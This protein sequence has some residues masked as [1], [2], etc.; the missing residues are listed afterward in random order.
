MRFEFLLPESMGVVTSSEVTHIWLSTKL[1]DLVQPINYTVLSQ[2][3]AETKD[4][5]PENYTAVLD[6]WQAILALH[7]VSIKEKIHAQ[8]RTNSHG[9]GGGYLGEA[10]L[11]SYQKEQQ[12]NENEQAKLRSA[13]TP[14]EPAS[15]TPSP[16]TMQTVALATRIADLEGTVAQL[17]TQFTT[18]QQTLV[19]CMWSGW[20]ASGTAYAPEGSPTPDL[21]PRSDLPNAHLPSPDPSLSREYSTFTP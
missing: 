6:L 10:I 8:E 7:H 17:Q 15:P 20:R 11:A 4:T 13:E 9:S 14:V 18:L 21:C 5:D 2:L 1:A 19:G 12:W 3:A 16:E